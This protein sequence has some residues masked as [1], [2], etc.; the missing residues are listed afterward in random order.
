MSRA[1]FRVRLIS[2]RWVEERLRSLE[3]TLAL[4]EQVAHAELCKYVVA[5][6]T[7]ASGTRSSI[8]RLLGVVAVDLSYSV[9]V[10]LLPNFGCCVVKK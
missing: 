9:V 4:S 10:M 5:R 7:T 2:R 8:Q 3:D 1:A 6:C